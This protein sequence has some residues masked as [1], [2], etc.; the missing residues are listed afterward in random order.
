VYVRRYGHDCKCLRISLSTT[1]LSPL[2]IRPPP[3]SPAW[4]KSDTESKGGRLEQTNKKTNKQTKNYP[5][6]K[7]REVETHM[8]NRAQAIWA[9]LEAKAF[10][11]FDG[12]GQ[13]LFHLG[14]GVVRRQI[15]SVEAGK[16]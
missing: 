7:R 6:L 12:A 8:D 9:S 5:Q 14:L 15:Q 2:F 11:L 13:L 1:E 4:S 3:N 16:L 10:G